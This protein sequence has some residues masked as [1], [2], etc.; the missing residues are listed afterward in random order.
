MEHCFF[1]DANGT[2]NKWESRN[3]Y[4]KWCEKETRKERSSAR[5]RSL[6]KNAVHK[7]KVITGMSRANKS[8]FPYLLYIYLSF[9]SLRSFLINVS[10]SLSRLLNSEQ[11]TLHISFKHYNNMTSREIL[12]KMKVST[13]NMVYLMQIKHS[14]FYLKF[15]LWISIYS[16]FGHGCILQMQF[17]TIFWSSLEVVDL[18][19]SKYVMQLV[20]SFN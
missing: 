20:C 13:K 8:K 19:A 10:L 16:V 1:M 11:T 17:L 2:I 14:I 12:H 3:K 9:L 18:F 6:S 5:T 4:D 15:H 7:I